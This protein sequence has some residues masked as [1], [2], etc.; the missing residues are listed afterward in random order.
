MYVVVQEVKAHTSQRPDRLGVLLLPLDGMLVRR[1]VTPSSMSPV[2]IYTPG[3]RETEWSKALC[4][5]ER[6]D[7]RG[8]NPEPPEPEFE[9]LTTR[10][11]T[12]PQA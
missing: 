2:P 6:R 9:V 11:Q 4:L 5:R 10:S 12:H 8:L 7:G 3:G 1:W